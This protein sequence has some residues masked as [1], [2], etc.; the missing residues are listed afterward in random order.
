MW[1]AQRGG[2]TPAEQQRREQPD[3]GRRG[4]ALKAV[5]SAAEASTYVR[6]A[7]AYLITVSYVA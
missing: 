5:V 1:Y 6:A 4:T 3:G 2:Y 7:R